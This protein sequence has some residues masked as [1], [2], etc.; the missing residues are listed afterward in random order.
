M[1]KPLIN[2]II[3]EKVTDNKTDTGIILPNAEDVKPSIGKVVFVGNGTPRHPINL[4][5]GD[6]ILY[7]P[8][9]ENEYENGQ[10]LVM[11]QNVVAVL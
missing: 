7:K 8:K 5:P 3:I 11:Y 10:Y 1:E 2:K 9:T 4:E 6:H